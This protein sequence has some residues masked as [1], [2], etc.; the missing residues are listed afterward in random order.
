MKDPEAKLNTHMRYTLGMIAD[1]KG[2]KMGRLTLRFTS[3]GSGETLSISD[4]QTMQFSVRY[5][6]VVELVKETRHGSKSKSG[7]A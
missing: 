6:D 3:D 2:F 1:Q 4:E 7:L 5:K